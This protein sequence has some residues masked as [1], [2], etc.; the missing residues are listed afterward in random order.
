MLL[1]Q[2]YRSP[3]QQEMYL[4][5]DRS[6]GLQHVPAALLTRFGTPEEVMILKLESSRQLARVDVQQ[7]RQSIQEQGY[8]LQLPP[9]AAELLAARADRG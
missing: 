4:Y 9:S 2:V 1:C 7:V 3:R 6:V 5:V 8:F